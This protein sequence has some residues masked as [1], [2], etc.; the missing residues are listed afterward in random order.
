MASAL[1]GVSSAAATGASGLSG[2]GSFAASLPMLLNPTTLAV[3]AAAAAI[4]GIGYA[5]YDNQ[6]ACEEGEKQF[7]KISIAADDFTGRLKTNKSIW[8][9][10]FGEKL[11]LHFSDSY[12]EETKKIEEDFE[13]FKNNLGKTSDEINEIMRNTNLTP[14]QKDQQ[15]DEVYNGCIAKT[16]E[17]IKELT[18]VI[19]NNSQKIKLKKEK[20]I[21]Q[22]MFLMQ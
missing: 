9:E 3:V 10:I 19:N 7:E 11:E 14:S 5:F 6:K 16:D 20:K 8:T 17:K 22:N 21:I 1:G 13:N 18:E 15:I 4:G 12:K 2:L